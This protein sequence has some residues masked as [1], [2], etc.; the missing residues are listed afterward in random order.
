MST[1]NNDILNVK[2]TPKKAKEAMALADMIQDSLM[3]WGSPYR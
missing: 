3:I 1:Q 2:L